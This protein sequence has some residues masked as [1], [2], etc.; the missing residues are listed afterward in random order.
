VTQLAQGG[1]T[2]IES[3]LAPA[4]QQQLSAARLASAWQ[5]ATARWR[6]LLAQQQDESLTAPFAG[7]LNYRIAPGGVVTA[8]LAIY[9][10]M[11]FVKPDIAT[12][13]IGQAASM[14]A[15][16]LCAGA[17]GKRFS[18]PNSRVMI[19]QPTAGFTGQASDVEIHAKEVLK[20][21]DQ[22]NRIMAHHTGQPIEKIHADTDRDFFMSGEEAKAYGLVDEVLQ[23]LRAKPSE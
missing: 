5:Q 22:L 14:G 1:D 18:L 11:Q 16:L 13:C 2:A 12:Y 17:K 15:L 4:V 7:N 8:G 20:M 9:D 19:H 6:A 10:T 23:G 21:K 3:Q